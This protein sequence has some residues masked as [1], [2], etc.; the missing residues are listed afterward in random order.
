[1]AILSCRGYESQNSANE[2]AQ[3]GVK[4]LLSMVSMI[5]LHK[6]VT[7]PSLHLKAKKTAF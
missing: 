4:W 3:E 5:P 6:Y 7:L 2:R 1:M